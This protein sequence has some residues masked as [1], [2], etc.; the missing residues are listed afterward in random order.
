MFKSLKV[1]DK[2]WRRFAGPLQ[3]WR[4]TEVDESNNTVTLGMGWKFCRNCGAEIDE[5]LGWNCYRTVSY[6]ENILQ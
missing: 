6:L 3:C 2:A 1:G 5:D 4:V